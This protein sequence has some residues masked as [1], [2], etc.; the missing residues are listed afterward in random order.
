M[1]KHIIIIILI[2]AACIS[3]TF[4][5]DASSDMPILGMSFL[6]PHDQSLDVRMFESMQETHSNWVALIPEA[7][8]D[9]TTLS[10]KPDE[11][12][13]HWGNTIAAQMQAIELAKEAGFKVFL[14]PHIKLD[15]ITNK[16][17]GLSRLFFSDGDKTGGAVWRG[18]LKLKK[19]KDWQIWEQNYEDYIMQLVDLA[20]AMEV[21]MFCIG[22]E[23]R[24][25]VKHRPEF[26]NQL[27]SKV[28]SQYQGPIIYSANWDE[29]ES[30]SFWSQVDF[31]GIDAYFPIS[32]EETPTVEK[33]FDNWQPIKRKLQK[34]HQEN[35]KKIVLTEYGYRNVSYSG[36][37]PWEHDDGTATPNNAAQTNLYEAFYKTFWN[38]DWVA[39]GFAWNWLHTELAP[40]NTD[41]TVRNKP[42][43]SVLQR[44]YDT[45]S[46]GKK[47]YSSKLD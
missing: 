26:W 14:K 39:G 22:T 12:N 6:G 33:A 13:K 46:K 36:L 30:V 5:Q 28:R 44:W 29:F 35:G 19:E 11:E 27:I 31:I 37:R 18:D 1:K 16:R 40:E 42:A 10:L 17:S 32:D 4:A 23:L 38:E 2:A 9:R 3:N 21:D 15:T 34:L 7:I 45:S 43:F 25:F 8:L 41:F 24:E 20:V 47:L